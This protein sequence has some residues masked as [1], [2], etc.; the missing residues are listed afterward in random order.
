[1]GERVLIIRRYGGEVILTDPERGVL[2][3]IEESR[4]MAARDP[5]VFLPRQ[6][7][8]PLN[9]LAHQRATGPELIAQVDGTIHG[10]VAG[11]GTGGTLMGIASALRE[12]GH[13]AR[14]A[15]ARPEK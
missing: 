13:P 5:N 8:N 4:A 9:A 1:S 7:E 12:S 6:F 2:G 14:V 15:A 11:V 3:S 10:F